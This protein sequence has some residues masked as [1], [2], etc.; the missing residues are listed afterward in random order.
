MEHEVDNYTNHDWCFWYSY[1]RIIKGTG[2]LENKRM[3]GDHPNNSI[4]ENGQNTEKSVE[5]LRNLGLPISAGRP[6]L[7]II[8]KKKKRELEKL[9]T[10]LSRLTT[11]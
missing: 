11:E 3:S 10:L 2:G 9:S 1:Q 7:I 4:T 5:D 8:N 6:D